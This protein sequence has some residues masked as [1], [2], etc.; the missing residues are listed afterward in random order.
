VGRIPPPRVAVADASDCL[1]PWAIP[2]K[3]LDVH[4]ETPP[5]DDEWTPDD[6]FDTVYSRGPNRGEPLPNPDVYVPPDENGPGTGFT[7]AEDLGLELTLKAGSPQDAVAPGFFL[8]VR[9]ERADGGSTGGSDYRDN[10]ATCNGVP[11]GIGDELESEPGNMIGPTRQGI[12]DLIDRD[13]FAEWDAANNSVVNSCAQ[14]P[15]PCAPR[16]PRLVAIPLY[17]TGAYYEGKQNGLV[18]LRI[19][20]I[21]GFFIDRLEGND[22][23][24]YLAVVPGLR[25]GNNSITPSAS[26]LKSIVLVR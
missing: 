13:P 21:L 19:A 17:D 26:F 11:I 9:L 24:G 18:T 2:D 6:T 23:V 22:V 1:K 16:S 25:T 15:V 3:W 10:I 14:D 8:P 7:L 20:N 4:D 12:Q 5:I